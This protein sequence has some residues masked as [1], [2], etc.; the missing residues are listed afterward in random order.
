VRLLSVTK[1]SLLMASAS[2]YTVFMTVVT[3]FEKS[4]GTV[5][6]NEIQLRSIC[7]TRYSGGICNVHYKQRILLMYEIGTRTFAGIRCAHFST[8]ITTSMVD[9]LK[10]KKIRL[11]DTGR[12]LLH[13]VALI[14]AE[15]KKLIFQIL[16]K[17]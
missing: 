1:V 12:L 14:V 10:K 16:M 13:C 6:G 8:V 9:I 4:F 17:K 2:G 11:C 5:L 15:S 3:K 7:Y